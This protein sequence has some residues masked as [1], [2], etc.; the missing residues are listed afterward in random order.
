MKYPFFGLALTLLGLAPAAWGQWLTQSF[1]LKPGWNAIFAQVDAS[2]A[3]LDNLVGS[4]P[5]NPILE[6]WRWNPPATAQFTDSP[7][8]PNAGTEW[9]SWVRAQTGGSMQRLVGDTAYLVRLPTNAANFKWTLKGRPVPP[10]N[11]WTLTGLNFLG[12]STVPANPPTF[13]QFFAK[14]PELQSAVPEVYYYSGFDLIHNPVRVGSFQFR[15]FPVKR[16]QAYWIRSGEVFNRYFGPFEVVL[17][18]AA[19]VDFHDTLTTYSLR[20]RNLTTNALTVSLQLVR[21][22]TPP[23]GQPAIAAEPPLLIRGQLNLADLT[24]TSTNLPVG[25]VR[26]WTLPARGQNGSEVEVVLGLNRTAMTQDAGALLAGVLRFTDSLGFSQVDV[27]V[28]AKAPATAGLWIGTAGVTDVQHYLKSYQRDGQ[29]KPVAGNDGNYVVTSVDGSLGKVTQSYPLRLIVHNP[30]SGHAVLLQRVFYG[31]DA[32]GQPVV[33]RSEDALGPAN[34]GSARRVSALHL[35][36]TAENSTWVFD[37]RIGSSTNLATT[38]INGYNDRASNPFLHGYHPDH[39]N[40]DS[41]FKNLQPQ[42]AESYTI[43]RDI[44]LIFTPPGNDFQSLTSAG[45]NLSG[46][47]QET[48][49]M[50]GLARGNGVEDNRQ[51]QVRGRFNLS[52]VSDLATLAGTP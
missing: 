27:P 11:Q 43:Q 1:D 37:G 24:Y 35:P 49:T 14:A 16:G 8:N 19:G 22:E 52:L 4:D 48:I 25:T 5:R 18:S 46:D 34:L 31:L 15:T 26:S 44:H 47:Y 41:T 36:W 21:S 3:T 42:G 9:T 13:D 6:V 28:A 45:L 20:L 23:S 30:V 38:V 50:K 29:G 10:R 32:K 51:F 17:S 7:Q 2:H 40:L 39:D 12:F 33:S